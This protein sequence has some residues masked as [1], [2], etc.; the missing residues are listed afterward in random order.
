[1]K[2]LSRESFSGL[3][4]TKQIRALYEEGTFIV[5]IRYYKYKVNLYQLDNY[6]VEVFYNHKLDLI[7]RTEIL[8]NSTTRMKFYTD[9]IRLPEM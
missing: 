4:L 5:A 3:S 7:E 6:F 2:T 1:M 8:S 9:Q